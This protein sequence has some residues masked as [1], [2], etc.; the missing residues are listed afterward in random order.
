MKV[1]KCS[2]LIFGDTIGTAEIVEGERFLALFGFP[3]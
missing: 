2:H 1:L 3:V